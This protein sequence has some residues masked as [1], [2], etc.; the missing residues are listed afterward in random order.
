MG[1]R[2]TAGAA[3]SACV[4]AHPSS[5]S[6]HT[7]HW[8]DDAAQPTRTP[9]RAHQLQV[10]ARDLLALEE[11]VDQVDGEAQRLGHE[12]E[13][14]VHLDEPVDQDCAH[15]LVDVRLRKAEHVHVR[16]GTRR[17]ASPRRPRTPRTRSRERSK[18][19][20]VGRRIT[21]EASLT[22]QRAM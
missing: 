16:E 21:R 13:L 5:S 2:R 12:L 14:E 8:G 6:R 7:A 15:A 3:G 20:L 11:A 19:L 1:A 9:K 18:T 10:L 22:W 4:A 17:C